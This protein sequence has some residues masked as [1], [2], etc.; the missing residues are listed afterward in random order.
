MCILHRNAL[1]LVTNLGFLKN[2]VLKL[3]TTMTINQ[4]GLL[5]Q[6]VP[7]RSLLRKILDSFD[8]RWDCST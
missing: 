2:V 7:K 5:A 1:E 3:T 6:Q 8:F 4:P